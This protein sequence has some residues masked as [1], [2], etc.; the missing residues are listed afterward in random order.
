MAEE[1]SLDGQDRPTPRLD[2]S[3]PDYPT[4][5]QSAAMFNAW[6]KGGREGLMQALREARIRREEQENPPERT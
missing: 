3:L 6:K 2:P 4:P 5:E 1:P